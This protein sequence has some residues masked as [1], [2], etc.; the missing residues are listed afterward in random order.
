VRMKPLYCLGCIA[1]AAAVLHGQTVPPATGAQFW[2]TN[3][4][5]DCSGSGT[6]PGSNFT[7]QLPSGGTGYV[8][9]VSGNFIWLAAGAGYTTSIRVAAP[10]ADAAGQP[11]AVGVDYSFYDTSGKIMS[12]DNTSPNGAASSGDVNFVLNANQPADVDL[13]GVPGNG[14]SYPTLVSGSVFAVFF[15]PD[16]ITCQAV[17]PQLIYSAPPAISLS[18]PL[19]WDGQQWT[20]WSATGID[21]GGAHRV[22]LVIFNLPG[23][24]AQSTV[25]TIYTVRVYDS[26]GTLVGTGTTPA[27]AEYGTYGDLLSNIVKSQLPSGIFKIHIDG[28]SNYSQAI[29]IQA[30]GRALT[31]VQVGYD[32]A[33]AAGSSAMISTQMSVKRSRA[34]AK[35]RRP[36]GSSAK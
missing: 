4:N 20:Q 22:S 6:S 32:V 7:R 26:T 16:Y 17:A 15:C 10:Q 24:S 3:P 21:D 30:N 14:P 34:L 36:L 19:S 8:C 9:E 12:L 35:T 5:L 33:P 27:V 2:S 28:G 31:T 25:A 29:V 23:P 18:V 11:S 13:L 1:V